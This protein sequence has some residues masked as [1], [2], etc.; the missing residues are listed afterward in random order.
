MSTA[1][2]DKVLKLTKDFHNENKS[3]N[4]VI[5]VLKE[6]EDIS[7]HIEGIDISIADMLA[8]VMLDSPRF[9]EMCLYA[10]DNVKKYKKNEN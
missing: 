8:N 7:A 6:G 9:Y 2:R 5:C 10:I 4:S 1:K 3:K